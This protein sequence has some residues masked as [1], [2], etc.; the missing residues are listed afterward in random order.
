MRDLG[1]IPGLGRFPREGNGYPV[2]YFLPWKSHGRRSLV[3]ATIHGFAK[4]SGTTE[5]LHFHFITK[6]NLEPISS[7]SES[8]LPSGNHSS[9]FCVVDF[10]ILNILWKCDHTLCGI[11]WHLFLFSIIF[12]TCLG[13]TYFNIFSCY[14]LHLILFIMGE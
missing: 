11:L 14:S 12:S 4:E 10:P 5:W 2:Q 13:W 3:Q 6:R 8:F 1:L 7:Y 9:A